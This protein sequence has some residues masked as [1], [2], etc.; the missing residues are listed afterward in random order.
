M[1]NPEGTIKLVEPRLGNLAGEK[2][3]HFEEHHEKKLQQ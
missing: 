1:T 2:I 3:I